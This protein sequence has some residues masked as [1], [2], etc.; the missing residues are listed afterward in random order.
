MS[1]MVTHAQEP[2]RSVKRLVKPAS[3][4]IIWGAPPP[5]PTKN[6]GSGSSSQQEMQSSHTAVREGPAPS[7]SVFWAMAKSLWI[8]VMS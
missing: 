2:S 4:M 1:A 7:F 8:S 3:F 6:D 5:A